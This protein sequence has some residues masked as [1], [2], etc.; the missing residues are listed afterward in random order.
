MQK[1]RRADIS[2][3][4][5]LMWLA[6]SSIP[7]ILHSVSKLAQRN[8]DPHSVLWTGV[9]HQNYKNINEALSVTSNLT[10]KVTK[11]IE[12]S[13]QDTCSI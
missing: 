9:K 10:E 12:N 6:I 5:K 1:S 7:D 8:K 11:L 13:T 3:G 4:R 2:S